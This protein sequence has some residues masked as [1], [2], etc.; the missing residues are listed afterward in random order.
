MAINSTERQRII[1][2][3]K[4]IDIQINNLNTALTDATTRSEIESYSTDSGQGRQ[5]VKRRDPEKIISQIRSLEIR[6]NHLIQRLNGTGVVN[7]RFGRR[8]GE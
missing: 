3:I 2:Q 1:D 5:S 7:F 4:T 6:R 8:D